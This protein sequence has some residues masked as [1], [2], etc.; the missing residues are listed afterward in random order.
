MT[1]SA[2]LKTSRLAAPS[3]WIA[4]G[5]SMFVLAWLFPPN[6][7]TSLFGDRDYIFLDVKTFLFC[8]ACISATLLG[9]AVVL[10]RPQVQ[11]YNPNQY[12]LLPQFHIPK[13]LLPFPAYF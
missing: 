8:F 5:A 10:Y 3:I 12:R 6:L 9:L 2:N 1:I 4:I 11:E 13:V 7:Y